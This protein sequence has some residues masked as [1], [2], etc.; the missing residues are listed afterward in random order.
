M[1]Q[2]KN[3]FHTHCNCLIID[4]NFSGKPEMKAFFYPL[5]NELKQIQNEGGIFMDING[6][7]FRF[8]PLIFQCNVDLPAKAE[9]Q[10]LIS[11]NGR[12]G[13]GY[14]Q[15]PGNAVKERKG[16]KSVIR[17]IKKENV[18]MRTHFN[19]IEAYKAFNP[20]SKTLLNGIKGISCLIGAKEFDLVNGF[21]IDYMHCV[22]LGVWKK[23]LDLWLSPK[24]H[25]EKHY[26]PKKKQRF[27]NQRILSIKPISEIGRKPRS[28]FDR[29]D[30]K[31]NELRS[32]LLYYMRFSLVGCLD[33]RFLS[34]FQL[35]SS[36]IYTLLQE[37][38]S[39]DEISEAETKLNKYADGF[40]EHYGKDNVTMN[41]HLLR[42]LANSVRHLGALW[43]Q[44]TFGFETNNGVLVHSNQS[45]DNYLHQLSW[46]YCTKK[47]IAP[48]KN[49][50]SGETND[51]TIIWGGMKT[52]H[53][54]SQDTKVFTDCGFSLPSSIFKIYTHITING[55]KYKSERSKVVSTID[56]FVRFSNKEIGAVKY[57][58]VSSNSTYAFAEIY[59]E[60]G[61]IDH[62]IQIEATGANKLINID[63]ID[64][65][66]IYMKFVN[67]HIVTRI[68]N[69]Y[70][71]T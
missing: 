2:V 64:Y 27:L 25:K 15:H 24:Y 8:L 5:L 39:C 11:Y 7:E 45:R 46:K 66:L 9:V 42:H 32:L 56:Y 29:A 47:E 38:I 10:C 26:I 33:N 60:I 67:R 57:Y 71:K 16:T 51:Q 35:L 21:S 62:L 17:F 30:F 49:A 23:Q 31:A 58:F 6:R 69:R 63:K 59:K 22:L 18:S 1:F 28:I 48:R 61:L 53:I 65:K 37:N 44:S 12:F 55:V 70:E 20:K 13:C 43:T 50:Q 52:M 68:P 54:D 3:V 41:V 40:E 4:P 19:M 14:C 34:H 36:S